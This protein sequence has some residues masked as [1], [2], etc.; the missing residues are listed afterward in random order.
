MN[1]AELRSLLIAGESRTVEFKKQ[2]NDTE[3]V[4]AVVC[5]ANGSGGYLIVGVTGGGRSVR[6]RGTAITPTLPGSKP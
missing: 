5:L 4:E 6:S 1:P 2:V 3:L